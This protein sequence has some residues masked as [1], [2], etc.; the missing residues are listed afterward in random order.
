[1]IKSKSLDPDSLLA[2]LKAGQFYASTGPDI[3]NIAIE[4]DKLIVECDPARSIYATGAGALHRDVTGNGVT[5]AEF[6][7]EPFTH[8]YARITIL[9]ETGKAWSNP[10]FFD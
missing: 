6:D 4:G 7:I 8:S 10:I 9:A 3:H 1:M 5:R 2:A